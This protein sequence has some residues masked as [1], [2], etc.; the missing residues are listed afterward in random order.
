MKKTVTYHCFQDDVVELKKNEKDLPDDYVFVREEKS[1]KRTAAVIYP[2]FRLAGS[3]YV[4]AHLRAKVRGAEKIRKE[5]SGAFLYANHTQP[6][7]DVFLP[8]MIAGKKHIYTVANPVNL[9]VPVLGHFLP[10]LGIIP[11][12][13]KISHMKNFLRAIQTRLSQGA[14]VV[15]YPEA[16]VWP[17]YTKIRPFSD[18]SFR[19]P[20]ENHAP[21][22]VLTNTYQK[23]RFGP[24]PK[25]TSFVDGPFLPDETLSKKERREKLCREVYDCMVDRSRASDYEYIRYIEERE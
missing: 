16:H 23:C 25:M 12:P 21:V 10:M 9:D 20:V 11:I 5:Q 22:Y 2:I 6:V 4:R 15:V 19:F 13:G 14:V 3:V 1:W 17:Y 7:G 8:A 24:W 18:S